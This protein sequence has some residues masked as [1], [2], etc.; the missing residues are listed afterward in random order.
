MFSGK[1]GDATDG[2]AELYNPAESELE[3]G[4]KFVTSCLQV[5]DVYVP[6]HA[7]MYIKEELAPNF[8]QPK[9]KPSRTS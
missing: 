8:E 1:T 5:G 6:F 3:Q 4:N 2:V 9:K 7:Q